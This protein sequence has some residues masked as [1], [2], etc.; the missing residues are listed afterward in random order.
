MTSNLSLLKNIKAAP[1]NL[2]V[3]LLTGSK[4]T[5]THTGD[6]QLKNRLRLLKVFPKSCTIIDTDTHRVREKG[7]I[8]NG[9]YHMS[10]NALSAAPNVESLSVTTL[11]LSDQ[12]PSSVLDNKCSYELLY[13]KH[14]DYSEFRSFGCLAFSSNPDHTSDKLAPRVTQPAVIVAPDVDSQNTNTHPENTTQLDTSDSPVTDT[15]Y[16]MTGITTLKSMLSSMFKMKD[17]G[18][19]RSWD[20]AEIVRIYNESFPDDTFSMDEFGGNG[21]GDEAKSPQDDAPEDK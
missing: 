18:E 2:T 5:I 8:E 17:I 7:T 12:L 13:D 9:L 20:I 4:V 21:D 14:V 16:E 6:L 10:N 1:P 3:N 19:W 15:R 11:N